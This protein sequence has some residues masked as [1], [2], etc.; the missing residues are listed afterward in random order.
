MPYLQ[1]ERKQLFGE[2]WE[3]G[4]EAGG[5]K[6]RL[7]G[8]GHEPR[9]AEAGARPLRTIAARPRA[10]GDGVQLCPVGLDAEAARRLELLRAAGVHVREGGPEPAA[11]AA[12]HRV[13]PGPRP[14]VHRYR[15]RRLSLL[16]DRTGSALV[17]L[18]GSVPG[19]P[20]VPGEALLSYKR[21]ARRAYN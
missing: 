10:G 5:V 4:W 3:H 12:H 6:E 2:A 1:Q 16:P 7:A 8:P 17:R 19:H 13:G 9:G 15:R 14:R 18:E 21:A 20:H 11:V